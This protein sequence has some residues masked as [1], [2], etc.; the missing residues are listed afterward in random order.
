M[1]DSLDVPAITQRPLRCNSTR[2]QDR[3]FIWED[4]RRM[5]NVRVNII[6]V[7]GLESCPDGK[8]F[9]SRNA[10]TLLWKTVGCTVW[11]VSSQPAALARH[12]QFPGVSDMSS[13]YLS[14]GRLSS[15][16]V[17]SSDVFLSTVGLV[18]LNAS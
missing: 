12:R 17:G 14:F 4:L 16:D 9:L 1:A 5:G 15:N 11:R 3:L 2:K 8:A 18:C 7:P 10:N 6:C 13:K